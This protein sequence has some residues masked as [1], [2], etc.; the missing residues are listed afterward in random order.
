MYKLRKLATRYFLHD[1]ILF[2]KG[3]DG[4]PLWCLGP[5]EAKEM[6]KEVRIGECRE[7]QGIKKLYRCILQTGYCWPT[8]RRV[9]AEFVKKCHGCQ[10]QANLIH[11]HLQSLQSMV[12]LW[13]FHTLGLDLVGPINPPSNWYIWILVATEYFTKWVETIPLRKA[14]DGAMANFIKK[15]IIVRFGVPYRIISDNGMPFVNIEVRKMQEFYQVKHHWLSP[16]YP[17]GNG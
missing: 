3:Y 5:E 1:G 4:D 9:V 10:V 2:K 15:N 17:Q 7:H 13:P 14:T 12:T 8:M 6:L 11:T 16:Y